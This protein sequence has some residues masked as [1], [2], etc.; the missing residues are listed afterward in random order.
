MRRLLLRR[1]AI[2]GLLVPVLLAVFGD[3]AVRGLS[4]LDTIAETG[5][6]DLG[7]RSDLVP[8]GY[9]HSDGDLTG[10]C[11]DFVDLLRRQ[12]LDPLNRR[13]PLGVRLF[14]TDSQPEFELAIDRIV[15]LDCGPHA[16][17]ATRDRPVAVSIPFFVTGVQFFVKSGEGAI[18]PDSD[19][20][21]K[22]IGVIRG[23]TAQTYLETEYPLADLKIF[24]G[25][26]GVRRG[27]EGVIS[28]RLDAF[29]TDGIVAI[30]EMARRELSANEYQLIPDIPLT[31]EPY[32]MLLPPEDPQ[33][34]ALVDRAIASP[35]HERIWN[36][37]FGSI[38]TD[39]NLDLDGS[40]I[41]NFEGIAD[42]CFEKIERSSFD[43]DSIEKVR[44]AIGER[45]S[46]LPYFRFH[47]LFSKQISFT[48]ID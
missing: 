5:V 10:Y 35:E 44:M 37:W 41:V 42:R 12:L 34:K 13:L 23:T 28:G 45:R 25:S 16:I 30:G 24:Q 18:D 9:R 48:V 7:V 40:S 38:M 26:Y 2:A 19:L 39:L 27:I 33:W 29:A 36:R 46:P 14:P 15:Q 6:I 32:G 11:I 4:V 43:P 8:F 20:E 22:A 3:R 21:G 1:S 31:C 17:A 47:F